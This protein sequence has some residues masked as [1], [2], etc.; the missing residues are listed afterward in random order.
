MHEVNEILEDDKTG[1][2]PRVVIYFHS[3]SKVEHLSNLLTLF[4][5][6]N[7]ISDVKSLWVLTSGDREQRQNVEESAA[8]GLTWAIGNSIHKFP[9][10]SVHIDPANSP[11][12]NVLHLCNLLTAPPPDH[13]IVIDQNRCFVPRVLPFTL[14]ESK[15]VKA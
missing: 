12:T 6:R 11:E 8:V 7:M 5:K 13:E 4:Q 9:V 15:E 10:F 2:H 1:Y 3:L 14:T